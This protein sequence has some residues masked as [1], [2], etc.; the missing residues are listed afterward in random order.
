[1]NNLLADAAEQ[2]SQ[3]RYV[4]L[5]PRELLDAYGAKR[6]GRYVVEEIRDDLEE[7]GLI[8]QPDFETV[9]L[10]ESIYIVGEPDREASSAEEPEGVGSTASEDSGAF[11]E[12]S[13]AA[14]LVRGDPTYR[15]SK[16][17]SAT[18][19]IVSVKPDAPLIEAITI[20]MANDFSQVPV[21]PNSR[22]VVGV[23]SWRSIGAHLA[24][25]LDGPRPQT[26]AAREV[27]EPS[28][29]IRSNRSLFEAIPLVLAHEYVLVRGDDR[30]ISGLITAND[31]SVQFRTIS[32]PFILLSEI[33]NLLRGMIARRFDVSEL[34]AAR[35]PADQG[36]AITRVD[37][38][39][40]GEYVRLLEE[41][42]RW[43][44]SRLTVDRATFCQYLRD[45][46]KIRNEVMHFDPDGPDEGDLLKL[47]H[48]TR[49]LKDLETFSSAG[50]A[51]E[52]GG[53]RPDR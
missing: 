10:D 12:G 53:E 14:D 3:G 34:N 25:S 28:H 30:Q 1:M 36:R 50:D 33:E 27:I 9:W 24:L 39:T 52:G 18:Q 35:A 49:F 19:G 21:M 41:P 13:E 45:A 11:E 42:G 48:L 23:V 32:E 6:R 5:T 47:R 46:A 8:T 40:F 38:L 16:L 26:L 15:I 29:E 37:D 17:A 7:A 31:L 20:M 22:D 2:V 4:V 51:Q 43:A 44:K